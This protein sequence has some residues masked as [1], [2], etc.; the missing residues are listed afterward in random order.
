MA[1]VTGTSADGWSAVRE[2]EFGMELSI[3]RRNIWR[4]RMEIRSHERRLLRD[5]V[6]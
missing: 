3:N 5:S 1:A 2:R 4:V 6:D